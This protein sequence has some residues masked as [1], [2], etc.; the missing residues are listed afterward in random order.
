MG[1]G[2]RELGIG[3]KKREMGNGKRETARRERPPD[4]RFP[5]PDS[6]HSG[7]SRSRLPS[8]AGPTHLL[9]RTVELLLYSHV[10]GPLHGRQEFGELP[11]LF[12]EKAKSMLLHLDRLIEKPRHSLLIRLLLAHHLFAEADTD[13]PLLLDEHAAPMLELAVHRSDLLELSVGESDSLL[14]RAGQPLPDLLLQLGPPGIVRR[15][16][17]RVGRC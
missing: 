4:Y 13:V 6:R 17:L 1:I 12:L 5:I 2:N 3:N 15:S 10:L 8:C 11:L 14:E 16:A 9:Q 7:P